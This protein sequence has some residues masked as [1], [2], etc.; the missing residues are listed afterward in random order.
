M[1]RFGLVAVVSSFQ[2]DSASEV[3][4]GK[5]PLSTGAA[6]RRNPSS[7]S[8]LDFKQLS[9][10]TLGITAI[11]NLFT[12]ILFIYLK[13]FNFLIELAYHIKFFP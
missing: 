3:W 9:L 6:L 2:V 13:A 4:R 7:E 11:S 1:Y 5:S 12:E 10:N 8:A